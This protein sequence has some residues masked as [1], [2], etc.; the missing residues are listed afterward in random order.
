[1]SLMKKMGE[2]KDLEVI[3]EQR[4]FFSSF[5]FFLCHRDSSGK[6]TH[7]WM[8]SLSHFFACWSKYIVIYST[9]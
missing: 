5:S 3:K 2:E 9:E 6:C 8:L 4:D 1:M 7:S